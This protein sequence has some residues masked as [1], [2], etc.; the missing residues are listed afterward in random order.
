MRVQA[1]ERARRECVSLNQ[2]I[3]QAV[4]EK[5]TRME[6]AR[7]HPSHNARDDAA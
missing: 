3:A 5:I 4:A 2:F 6:C 1:N 7:A